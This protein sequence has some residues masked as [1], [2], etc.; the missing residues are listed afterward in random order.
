MDSFY[1]KKGV[2]H[3][4]L[5]SAVVSSIIS[6]NSYATTSEDYEKALTAFNQS[7][8]DEA[9]IHLKNSL[10]K[11]PENLAAKI[12]MGEILLI[13][14]Y[15]TAAEIEF[16]EALEMGADINLLA[17]PLGNTWLFLNKYQEIV[18]FSDL[19]KLSG[20]AERE[21][22]MVRATAC[23]RLEDELCALRD[24]N[25]V[26][27]S[28]PDFVP[29]IN[30]LA[31]IALQNDE[32]TKAASLIEKAMSITPENAIT[33][34]LKGQLAY[35]QGD[36]EAA[37]AHLQKALTFNRD[38][39]IALRNLVDLYL[40]AKDYD[41]AKLF[42]D[43]IIQD[44]PND[45]L[46]I[47]LNSW[48]QSRDNQ[49]AI[50]NEKLKELNDFM[51]QLDPELITSQPMLLYISGLTNFFNNS[52][53][54]AAKDFNAYLQKEPEDLQAVLMLSQV[55]MATQQDKQ[56]LMLLERYQ[57][58]LMENP[59]SA[60]LLGDLLIRQNKAFKAERLLQNLEYKYP[61]ENKLQ[62]FK[63]KLMAARGKE[64]EALRILEM[65]LPAYKDNAGFLFTYSLMN[66]QAQRYDNALKGANLLSEMFPE[67]AE[68][69][70]LKAGIFI[71]QGQLEDAK[72]NIE[73]A[74]S[75]NPTL[76][77]AK[78]NLAATES[79]LGNIEQSNLLVEELLTLSPQHNETLMLKAFNLAKAGNIDEA[80]QIYLDILTLTP[81]N[82]G[83]RERVSSLYQRQGDTK[84]ALYHL[85]LLIKD[86][87]DNADYLL[88]KA[89][90]QFETNQR[91][92]AEK[93]LSIVRNFINDDAGKLISYAD[94]ARRIGNDKEAKE[95]MARAY[96]IASSSILVTLRYSSLLLDF[97]DNDKAQSILASVPTDQQQNP[98]YH[99]LRGRLEANK[100]NDARAVKA[101]TKALEIDT[102][103]AQ[104]FV[105]LYNYA[106]NEQ[107]V[108][109]FLDTARQLVA[110]NENNLLAKN[111]L[112][113]Y[114]FFI[115][116]YDESIALYKEL[117][118]E[119]N[120]LSLAEAF[121]RLAIMHVDKSLDT[122]KNYAQQA[123]DL[124]PNSAK[125]LDTYG[126]IKALQGDFEGSLKMLRDAFARDANDPNIRYH[127][128]Y[129]LAKLERIEEA[130]KELEFAV[131][132]ER[133]FFK[134]PQAQALLES[135]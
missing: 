56:A 95:A 129:T 53:E 52:M 130:K 120:L 6:F 2:V 40:E 86:E 50:D 109:V 126:H 51:A 71:R 21:W 22:L 11:D 82:T 94:Q 4:A 89:A 78:F 103:F 113:Q 99:F 72:A 14:G 128:G 24:Y 70:N 122:A 101:F 75:R 132:V 84:N 13:N 30:G 74:L 91:A 67:E 34:R 107:F 61:N 111:L 96:E 102:A 29:A 5:I 47:L 115:Q 80:K 58:A 33:W 37:T 36:K 133:P 92:D 114:L 97:Q 44:T 42:V 79:R 32:L 93:T 19:N 45:P 26:I 55:Y 110:E 105:A 116:E 90:L 18:D 88:Q 31:S 17:E 8:F 15:L 117:I 10:Q 125:I 121:N 135:L 87:F 27:S 7:A 127:L 62:L 49:Q 48:L 124:Q 20:D 119:P 39:P 100:G 59:D 35:R 60:L 68:V 57:D 16:V 123:H 108:D 85:D 77:P 118:T 69:Y 63:I 1:N 98:V 28:T 41:S 65:N 46:A 23:I 112:A 76:F 43:E 66:L 25:K 12:L 104:A 83:A 134:R 131:N 38:D 64:E 106:L 9:Y 81:S 3:R 54:S 73:K